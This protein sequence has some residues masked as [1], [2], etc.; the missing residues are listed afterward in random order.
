MASGQLLIFDKAKLNFFN[1]TNLL[2][3][4]NT[5]KLALHTSTWTP[6][7]LTN[8]VFA[9]ATNELATANGY[10]AGGI[11]LAGVALTLIG[12]QTISTLTRSGAVATVT[13]GSAH[14]L[15]TG[16]LVTLQGQN[17]PLYSGTFSITVTGATTFTYTMTGTP[18][19]NATTV[20]AYGGIVKYTFT[21]PVWTA[22]GGSIPA[23]RS[24]TLRASGTLNGKVDPLI[25]YF[26]GD[27]TNVDVPAT[28][29]GNAL[30]VTPPTTGM[31]Q[32]A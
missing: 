18:G 8:E 13:T 23:W 1:A 9:D 21:A 31:I 5:F 15:A 26:L 17:D 16:H 29:V 19:A 20:G 7:L 32:A 24:A 14:G 10:T 4:G 3:A 27:A 22:S 12:A 11:T 6:N 28:T 25:G 30:T 2:N